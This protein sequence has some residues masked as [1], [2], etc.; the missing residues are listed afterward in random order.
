MPDTAISDALRTFIGRAAFPCVGAKAAM[1]LGNLRVVRAG[2]MRS[3]AS[4]ARLTRC[5]Q[6][7]AAYTP[8][9]SLFVSLAV[10]FERTGAMSEQEFE[11]A[12]WARLQSIHDLD[13]RAYAWDPAVSDDPA[14]PR[15]SMSI[16]SRAFYVVGLHPAASRRARR[17]SCPLLVFNPH[18]Q[19]E[20]LR[21]DGRYE[22]LASAITRR[23][24]AFSGS[25]NPML[26]IH[27]TVSEA[28]QYSGRQVDD[29]W[30]CP[31]RASHEDRR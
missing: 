26:A 24:I 2:D 20:L 7:F 5:L 25:R 3:A 18:N 14:S 15:F 6:D 12:L 13:S 22:K 28:R 19:F 29:A 4:D 27:G 10:A 31:F 21:A 9:A 8:P 1:A 17:F 23:D 16:G 30:R 11:A